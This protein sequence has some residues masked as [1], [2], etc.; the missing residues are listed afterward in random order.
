MAITQSTDVP[1]NSGFSNSL[2]V[3][4][5]TADTSIAA[6]DYA[7]LDQVIEGYNVV[8]LVG[9]PFTLSF[10][11]KSSKTGIHCFKLGNINGDRSYIA[12]YTISAANT[13]EKKIITISVGIPADGTWNYTNGAGLSV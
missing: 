8:D 13:W 6:G 7:V 2:R 10:W 3:S 9:V 1:A 12:E 11:V 4:V 5:S